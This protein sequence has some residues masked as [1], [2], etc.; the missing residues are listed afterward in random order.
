[1]AIRNKRTGRTL[2]QDLK[3]QAREVSTFLSR[4]PHQVATASERIVQRSFDA[5]Q[6]QGDSG[7]SPWPQRKD[8]DGSRRLLVKSARLRRNISAEVRGRDIHLGSDL[9][10]AQVHNEGGRAGRGSGFKMPQRQYMPKPGEACPRLESDV[11]K[12]IT[13]GLNKIL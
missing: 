9:D 2:T 11:D 13:R 12:V 8:G 10:Y 3:R 6:Y 7:S 4:L 5:E 1:M